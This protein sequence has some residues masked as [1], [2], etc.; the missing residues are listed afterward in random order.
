LK[1]AGIIGFGSIGSIIAEAFMEAGALKPSQIFISTRTPA[2]ILKFKKKYSGVKIS[3]NNIELAK[4]SGHIF[5]CVRPYDF[6]NVITEISP[7]LKK[8]AHLINVSGGWDIKDIEKYFSGAITQAIPSV[9]SSVLEGITVVSHNKKVKKQ[10]AS[11]IEGLFKKIGPVVRVNEKDSGMYANITGCGPGLV[12]V[13]ASEMI[14]A[15]V[16]MGMDNKEAETFVTS[17]FAGTA[18]MGKKPGTGYDVIYERVAT[19]GGIT[20]QGAKVLREELP[21]TFDEMFI[22]M[23]ERRKNR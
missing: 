12:A 14:N 20:E 19:K 22:M 9:L 17:L 5:I 16:R 15:A 23:F 6:E 3:K 8:S 21:A 4:N 7:Y 13:M 18:K 11:Y 10:D 1:T 2:K